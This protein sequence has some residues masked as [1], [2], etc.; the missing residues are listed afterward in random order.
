MSTAEGEHSLRRFLD[1][2]LISMN[3]AATTRR[4][5]VEELTGLLVRAGRVRDARAFVADVFRREVQGP[6]GLGNAIAIPHGKSAA[7]LETSIAIGRAGRDLD[8]PSLDGAP[9]RTV[10][11]LAVREKDAAI[12]HLRLLQRIAVLLAHGDFA[13]LLGS[14]RDAD[15]VIDLIDQHIE[16]DHS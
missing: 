1:P 9:V 15:D 6:T 5:A 10:F 12:T 2:R 14:A 11:L 8:W 4:Q 7:V 13:R 16:E 3:L